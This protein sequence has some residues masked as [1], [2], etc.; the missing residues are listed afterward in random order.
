MAKEVR[1]PCM[2]VDPALFFPE[3]NQSGQ[4]AAMAYKSARSVCRGCPIE[5]WWACLLGAEN[6]DIGFFG[7]TT[8][9]ERRRFFRTGSAHAR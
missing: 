7:S 9:R 4:V 5:S 2:D 6:E 3:S 1:T 8:P